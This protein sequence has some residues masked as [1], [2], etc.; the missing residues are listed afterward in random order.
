MAYS[1]KEIRTVQYREFLSLTDDEIR[2]ILTDIFDPVKIEN[3]EKDPDFDM[4]TA[5][6]T[7]SGW[8]DG[9]SD[10]GFEITD[11]VELTPNDISIDFSM[12]DNDTHKYRQFLLAK[13]CNK[14]LKDN[15]YLT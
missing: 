7:T 4:I 11:V 5:E 2:F 6:I 12:S 1:R 3:I 10:D 13:G 8:D 9:E 14:L 15:P